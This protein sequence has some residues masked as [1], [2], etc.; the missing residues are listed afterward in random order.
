MIFRYII[1]DIPDLFQIYVLH[2]FVEIYQYPILAWPVTTKKYSLNL[3]SCLTKFTSIS[4]TCLVHRLPLVYNVRLGSRT[5]HH[6][7]Q[8]PA[9]VHAALSEG[10][11]SFVFRFHCKRKVVLFNLICLQWHVMWHI[12]HHAMACHVTHPTMQWHVMWHIPPCN[13]MSC[14]TSH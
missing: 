13:G 1:S 6:Q 10:Q 12:S 14:D 2:N 11:G 7:L 5:A 9:L 4:W 8:R 3:L